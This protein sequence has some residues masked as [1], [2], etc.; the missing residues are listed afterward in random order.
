MSGINGLAVLPSRNET[1]REKIQ[2]GEYVDAVVIGE[3]QTL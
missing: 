3:I 1:G 2:V